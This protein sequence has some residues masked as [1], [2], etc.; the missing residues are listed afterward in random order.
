MCSENNGIGVAVYQILMCVT[1]SHMSIRAGV[2]RAVTFQQVDATPHAE[3]SAQGNNE[4]L[5]NINGRIEKFHSRFLLR[6]EL[7]AGRYTPE[8]II[9]LAANRSRV[10]LPVHLGPEQ[11]KMT[12]L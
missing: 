8:I 2:V 4:G 5:Q 7:A 10:D 12:L 11:I 1:L 3:T 6:K 9:L